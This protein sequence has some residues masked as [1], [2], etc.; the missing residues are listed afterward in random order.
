MLRRR[1]PPSTTRST[2]TAARSARDLTICA[3]APEPTATET[4]SRRRRRRAQRRPSTERHA[5]SPTP[6]LSRDADADARASDGQRRSAHAG[7]HDRDTAPAR[8]CPPR[9][10]DGD[11]HHGHERTRPPCAPTARPTDAGG[12]ESRSTPTP[13]ANAGSLAARRARPIADREPNVDD[14]RQR[15]QHG[16]LPIARRRHVHL[17]LRVPTDRPAQPETFYRVGCARGI[18]KHVDGRA[19]TE[20]QQVASRSSQRPRLSVRRARLPARPGLRSRQVE[21]LAEQRRRLRLRHTGADTGI[22]AVTLE[23]GGLPLWSAADLHR[24]GVGGAVG[25]L[26]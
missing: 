16:A 22:S 6:T 15:Q 2:P 24:F 10:A 19:R 12:H 25:E 26:S 23:C 9:H 8:R 20:Q 5:A 11:A 7:R 13:T 17:R 4:P 3:A 14:Q 18:R 1:T 21:L